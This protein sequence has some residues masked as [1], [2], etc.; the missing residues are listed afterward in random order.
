M[1]VLHGRNWGRQGIQPMQPRRLLWVGGLSPPVLTAVAWLWF[2]AAW[3]VLPDVSRGTVGEQE[4]A[5]F[6]AWDVPVATCGGVTILL[7]LALSVYLVIRKQ[8]W[9][10]VPLLVYFAGATIAILLGSF[11]FVPFKMPGW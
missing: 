4:R 3:R 10:L 2:F 6:W 5:L 8:G 1:A 7:A 9:L 11:M